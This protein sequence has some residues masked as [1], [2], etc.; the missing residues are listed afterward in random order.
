M[1]KKC[2]TLTAFCLMLVLLRFVPAQMYVCADSGTDFSI[3]EDISV[4]ND[5]TIESP[6][7]SFEDFSEYSQMEDTEGMKFSDDVQSFFNDIGFD[8]NEFASQKFDISNRLSFDSESLTSQYEEFVSE[9]VMNGYGQKFTIDTELPEYEIDIW[10]A[11]EEAW[12]DNGLASSYTQ[13]D[14]NALDSYSLSDISKQASNVRKYLISSVSS[15]YKNTSTYGGYE[16]ILSQAQSV[17][18]NSGLSSPL[19]ITELKALTEDEK[20]AVLQSINSKYESIYTELKSNAEDKL[21]LEDVNEAKKE[22]YTKDDGINGVYNGSYMDLTDV[23]VSSSIALQ[24]LVDNDGEVFAARDDIQQKKYA[25]LAQGKDASEYTAAED[26]LTGDKYVTLLTAYNQLKSNQ[27]AENINKSN[28][29]A[30]KN[31][32]QLE[33]FQRPLKLILILCKR[34]WLNWKV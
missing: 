5:I 15:S 27:V 20:E 34:H 8:Y 21:I 24:A 12:G 13:I 18:S 7:I 3:P 32:L 26:E 17:M 14:V 33:S 28:L 22:A 6:E 16:D 9:F 1:K 23:E 29:N 31:Y 19:S 10:A 25:L 30:V 4:A 2:K 11:Y